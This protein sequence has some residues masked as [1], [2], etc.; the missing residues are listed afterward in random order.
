MSIGDF[1][2]R[3]TALLDQAS[4]PYMVAGSFASSF[5][6]EP[7][8]TQDVDL[9]VVLDAAGVRRLIAVLPPDAYYADEHAALDAVRRRTQFNVIDMATG[10]K[11]DLV[12]RKG[13]PFSLAEFARRQLVEF[14]G[15]RLWIASP[16][17]VVV[18]KLEW[19][20]KTGS[21]RQLRDVR[22]VLAARSE[23]LDL[24]Y[25]ERWVAELGLTEEWRRVQAG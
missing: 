24:A 5:H 14:L 4:I 22:G 3:L 10:W 23:P 21:E 17:D 6:G 12:V 8:T 15:I 16:E 25:I 1:I 18:S 2:G 9:V 19:A 11:A 13:R 20:Q 7:R